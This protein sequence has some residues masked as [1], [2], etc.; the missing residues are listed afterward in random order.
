MGTDAYLTLLDWR[1]HV[2]N[3]YAEIRERIDRDPVE[4]HRRWRERRDDLF[5]NHPQ[6]ALPSNERAVFRGLRYFAYD[7]RFAFT[8]K[9]RPLPEKRYDIATSPGP[10][11]PFVRFGAVDLPIGTL[12]V[13]WLD[14]YSG[15]LFLG[16]TD[17]TSSDAT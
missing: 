2:S 4:A 17:L 8:A 6:S 10:V 5:R 16:F 15:G 1:R 13:M 9:I 11:M 7:S 14:A 12:E 3:M